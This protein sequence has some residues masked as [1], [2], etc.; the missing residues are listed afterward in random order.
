MMR[1]GIGSG[2]RY[3]ARLA[4]DLHGV[5]KTAGQELL[6]NVDRPA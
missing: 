1:Y 4:V 6:V 3:V 2:N 5:V